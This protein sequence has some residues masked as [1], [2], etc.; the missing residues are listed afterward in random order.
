MGIFDLVAIVYTLSYHDLIQR[1]IRGVG[2]SVSEASDADNRQNILGWTQLGL[3]VG[4]AVV[5]IVWFYAAYSNLRLLGVGLTRGAYWAVL[6]WLIPFVNLVLPKR[7][8]NDIWRGS[9]P[10]PPA[11]GGFEAASIPWFHTAW[12]GLF[13]VDGIF[14][15]IAF[16][17]WRDAQS[18]PSLSSASLLV[19]ASY[20]LD[21]LTILFA[22]AVV[23]R[24]VDRQRSRTQKLGE[25]Q[26]P[27]VV[28]APA[29]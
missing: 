13:V 16:Q 15:R 26:P 8:A 2:V 11:D 25:A 17:R 20:A 3:F 29:T 19:V 22:V 24:T 21:L 10:E 7:I 27:E 9:N 14:D 28:A 1:F 23:Y 6:G 18:L 4:V 5:F 12:W